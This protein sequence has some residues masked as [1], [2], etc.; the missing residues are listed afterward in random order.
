MDLVKEKTLMYGQ[1]LIDTHK[2]PGD[3]YHNWDIVPIEDYED[4]GILPDAR[5]GNALLDD[6]QYHR[7]MFACLELKTIH[8]VYNDDGNIITTTNVYMMDKRGNWKFVV[9]RN[10]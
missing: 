3:L 4:H 9:G 5:Y 2:E 8:S 6:F 7:G 1:C 10:D